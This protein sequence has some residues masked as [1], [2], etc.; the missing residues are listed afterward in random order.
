[1]PGRRPE[2]PRKQPIHWWTA[3]IEKLRRNC[4]AFR[5]A[6]QSCLKRAGQP[7]A[8][9]PRIYTTT[10]RNLRL[11]IGEVKTKCWSDLCSQ[12]SVDPCGKP[13]KIVTG[14]LGTRN[15]GAASRGREAEIADFLFP[16]APATNWTRPLP[17][18]STIFSRRSIP[19]ATS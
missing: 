6:Y 10:R 7:G 5:R 1:M 4:L 19:R 11:K 14:K 9:A 18:Q 16:A 15:P 8:Q 13:Y 12:V 17:W 3:E 2:P